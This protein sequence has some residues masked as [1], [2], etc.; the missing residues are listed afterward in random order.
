[1]VRILNFELEKT[2]YFGILLCGVTYGPKK[3]SAFK[4]EKNKLHGTTY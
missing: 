2:F 4:I 3:F 1:M